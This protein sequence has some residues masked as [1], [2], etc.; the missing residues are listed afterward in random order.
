MNLKEKYFIWTAYVFDK[1]SMLCYKT[2]MLTFSYNYSGNY[3]VFIRSPGLN[4]VNTIC[5]SR[6]LLCGSSSAALTWFQKLQSCPAYPHFSG[7]NQ[8][9]TQVVQDMEITSW[10]QDTSG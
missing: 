9:E 7:H 1:H 4:A 2:A 3:Q 8:S 5:F 10:Y 6:D